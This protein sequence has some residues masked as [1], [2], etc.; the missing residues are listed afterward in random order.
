MTRPLTPIK[1]LGQDGKYTVSGQAAAQAD[2][3]GQ[4]L[5][6]KNAFAPL[7]QNND[8]VCFTTGVKYFETVAAAM[9]AAKKS[10]FIAGWQVNWDVQMTAS[11][12]LI[13]ILHGRI[14]SSDTFRVFV[15]PWLSPKIGVNTNDLE[16][17][18]AIFQLNAGRKSTQAMCCPAGELS[19]YIGTEGAAFSHHQKLVV[20]DNEIAYVGGMDLAYGRRDDEKFSLDLKM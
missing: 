19:D 15:L 10:I 9:K 7:R 13:D 11:E 12:R 1:L 4:D 8:V 6:E 2:A 5:L 18:L 17:M 16:T 20:I 3:H 14:Q